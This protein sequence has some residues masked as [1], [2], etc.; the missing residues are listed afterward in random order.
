MYHV[1]TIRRRVTFIAS[2]VALGIA[3]MGWQGSQV[4]AVPSINPKQP[5]EVKTVHGKPLQEVTVGDQKTRALAGEVIV[6][7]PD[8]SKVKFA[9]KLRPTAIPG[10]Y[11]LILPENQSVEQAAEEARRQGA[12]MAAPNIVVTTLAT[13]N[14]PYYGPNQWNMSKVSAPAAWDRTTG[15]GTVIASVDTG[16]NRYHQDL[17]GKM[18]TNAREVAG[19]GLDDDRNGYVDDSYGMDFVADRTVGGL[20]ASDADGAQDDN[21]H[22]SMTASV[23]AAST[24]NGIGIAGMD[25]RSRIMPLKVMDSGGGGSLFDVA[26]AIRYAADNGSRVVNLSLGVAGISA[27]QTTDEAIAYAAA[28]GVVVVAAAGNSGGN[29]FYPARHPSVVAVGATDSNDV[30]ASYSAAGPE[31]TLVA[32]GSGVPCVYGIVG[33]DKYAVGTGTSLAAPHVAGTAAL[34]LTQR[35]TLTAKDIKV[36]LTQSADKVGGMNGQSRTDTY[37]AGRLNAAAALG[38]S[39]AAAPVLRS[40]WVGQSPGPVLNVGERT[41]VYVDYLNTGTQSWSAGGANPMNLGTSRPT[42]RGS[43]FYT[44]GSWLAPNR[45]ASIAGRVEQDGRVSPATTVNP[46]EKARFSFVLTA[47]QTFQTTTFR[48]Y[49]QPVVE[50]VRWMEDYGV[51]WDV[52]VKA[53]VYV[54]KWAGQSGGG[55]LDPGQKATLTLDLQNTGGTTWSRNGATP[56]RLGTSRP[57]DRRSAFYTSGSWLAPNRV[58]LTGIVANGQVVN[59]DTVAPGETGRFSFDVTAPST[60]GTYNEYFTPVIDGLAWLPDIGIYYPITVAAPP[61]AYD[62]AYV[63]QTGYPTVARGAQATVS[64]TLK[65]TGSKS[66]SEG[67]SSPFRL[68]TSRPNDRNSAFYDQASWLAQNRLKLTRN[69]SDAAKNGDTVTIA[70]G[71]V[72]EFTFVFKAPPTMP[73]G[74][75]REYVTPLV[76]GTSWLRDI[77]IFWFVTVT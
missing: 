27:D 19:N 67:G 29:V 44:S 34:L 73:S 5:S 38:T 72:G 10:T 8:S 45:P 71:E 3:F 57:I 52:T 49:V 2:A 23:L 68:G 70:P 63:G 47:P 56:F 43:A 28:K 58:Q 77:G 39:I 69:T 51:F 76:E 15:G 1:L 16:V 6:K 55:K 17:S 21:G 22:G 25:W 36:A 26:Q 74:T 75:Y 24:N 31:L 50:G 53:K 7:V 32:P 37:G 12:T 61:P 48:E 4:R 46:G 20:P 14:D 59:Q 60:P 42:D 65:N 13:P 33:N 35:P 30:Q 64:L 54:Y 18:W 62:Y 11:R 9:D 41:T 40:Q 66:W